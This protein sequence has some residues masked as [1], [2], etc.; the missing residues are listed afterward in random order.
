MPMTKKAYA[1]AQLEGVRDRYLQDLEALSDQAISTSPGGAARSPIHFTYEIIC[2]NRRFIK[3][4]RGEDPGPF[5]PNIWAT[6]P[7]EYQTRFG[8]T[9]GFRQSF[10]E[11]IDVVNSIPDDEID[12]EIVVP[13]GTTSPFDLSLFCATHTNYHDGQLNYIQALNGDPDI[14]WFD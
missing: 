7:S 2:V 3:R 8:A 5:D 10:E 12:R 13:N 14:H 4:L 9:E 11:L 1:I 6:T